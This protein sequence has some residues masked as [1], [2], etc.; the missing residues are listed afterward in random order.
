MRSEESQHRSWPE[1]Q[2]I[3][4]PAACA[5]V[6]RVIKAAGLAAVERRAIHKV[7]RR[8]GEAAPEF[9]YVQIVRVLDLSGGGRRT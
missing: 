9:G 8:Q 4:V 1:R 2:I 5:V 3:E 6:L 7:R